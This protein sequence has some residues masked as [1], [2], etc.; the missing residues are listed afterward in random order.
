MRFVTYF[1][2]ATLVARADVIE[3]DDDLSFMRA[4]SS[5][6]SNTTTTATTTAAAVTTAAASNTTTAAATTQ[7]TV[8]NATTTAAAVVTNATVT[9][10]AAT[11]EAATTAA[12]TT[13]AAT[14]EAAQV[15][16]APV[17]NTTAAPKE[18]TQSGGDDHGHD[19]SSAPTLIKEEDAAGLQSKIS[20]NST[21]TTTSV[22]V[23]SAVTADDPFEAALSGEEPTTEAPA[24]TT[25]ASSNATVSRMLSTPDPAVIAA[26]DLF[27]GAFSFAASTAMCDALSDDAAKAL[28]DKSTVSE[29]RRL[30]YTGLTLNDKSTKTGY[31][32]NCSSTVADSKGACFVNQGEKANA[33]LGGA[34][35]V[36]PSVVSCTLATGSGAG[37]SFATAV[38]MEIADAILEAT[39]A[40]TVDAAAIETAAA[41]SVS[42]SAMQEVLSTA[43]VVAAVEISKSPATK[44]VFEDPS[45]NV[46]VTA[47][48]GMSEADFNDVAEAITTAGG[49]A[50][51]DLTQVADSSTASGALGTT[52]KAVAAKVQQ[53]YETAPVV[54]GSGAGSATSPATP[55]MV[56][57]SIV[58]G[59]LSLLF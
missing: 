47:S 7:A 16:E 54:A 57:S 2:C 46:N 19:D 38:D 24:E 50:A 53:S 35:L 39:P 4:L 36:Y 32:D 5:N 26:H 42:S 40:I 45:L 13:E 33:A 21:D 9:T 27:C 51:L 55:V 25:E 14:T 17:A 10:E 29:A 11:T 1:A 12:A 15:T 20:S 31:D 3:E 43:L 30:C 49:V 44:A 34:I 18:E 48:L 8:S 52:L 59:L 28:F 58:V 41:A 23:T 6:A 22:S 37:R 56:G